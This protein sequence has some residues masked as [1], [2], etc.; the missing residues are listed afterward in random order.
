MNDFRSVIGSVNFC[1]TVA[2]TE[3]WKQAWLTVSPLFIEINLKWTFINK[4]CSRP[5]VHLH[6]LL[7]KK[8][9]RLGGQEFIKKT[10]VVSAGSYCTHTYT[11]VSG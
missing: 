6:Q 1:H 11:A 2:V 4:S 3:L 5:P 7:S 8:G 10:S 9:K